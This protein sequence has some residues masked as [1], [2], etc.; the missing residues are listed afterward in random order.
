[1]TAR[2]QCRNRN[3]C[4]DKADG[5][6]YDTRLGPRGG[7]RSAA[8]LFAQKFRTEP[9]MTGTSVSSSEIEPR[10]RRILFRAWHR[11][12]REMDLLMGSFTDAEIRTMS[13]DDLAVFEL[14]IEAP[15]RDIYAWITDKAETP[16]N[17]DT[18]LFRRLKVFHTHTSPI[19]V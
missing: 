18:P 3:L 10:R 19:H 7:M 2:Q 11:G 13:E 15:D 14:L 1:M 6:G 12:T 16:S 17:Y 4:A 9:S 8:L 5:P